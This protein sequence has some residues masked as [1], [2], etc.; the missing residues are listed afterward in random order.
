MIFALLFLAL[1]AMIYAVMKNAML[2]VLVGIVCEAVLTAIY[3]L[4]STWL[5]GA[6]Q[7]VLYVFDLTSH[8]DDFTSGILDLSNVVYYLTVTVLFLFFTVQS[9]EKRRWS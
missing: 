2:A 3:F 8:F 4:K 1:A 6:I 5:E 9:I 7:N